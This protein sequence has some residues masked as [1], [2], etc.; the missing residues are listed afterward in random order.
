MTPKKIVS[1]IDI[2]TNSFHMVTAE[3]DTER[4]IQIISRDKEYVRL[5]ASGGDMKQINPDAIQRGIETLDKFSKI[6]NSYNSEIIAIATS[7]VREAENKSEFVD[8][9]FE[10]TGIEIQVITGREEGRLIYNGAIHALPVSGKKILLLDIGGGST[11][12]VFGKDDKIYFCKSVKL[13]TVRLWKKYF[14]KEQINDS[15]IDECLKFINGEWSKVLKDLRNLQFDSV[16]FTSGT[17]ENLIYVSSN[18]PKNGNS[19]LANGSTVTAKKLLATIDRIKN[20]KTVNKIAKIDGLDPKRADIILG[21]SLIAEYFINKLKIKELVFSSYALR[22]GILY[23]HIAEI[24]ERHDKDRFSNL[25]INTLINLV[26]KYGVDESHSLHIW[27]LS[28]KIFEALKAELG[29]TN[30]DKEMLEAA[31]Y[32]H[33]VGFFISHDSHHKHSYYLIKNSEMPGF[34]NDESELIANIARYHRKSLPKDRHENF[35][36]LRKPY[37][38]LIWILGGILRIAEGLDRRQNSYVK[39][40]NLEIKDN[41]VLIRIEKHQESSPDIEIW[42]AER[43]KQMLEIILNKKISILM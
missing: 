3:I 16:V 40:I 41:E 12:T 11:E 15:D 4:N 21:G 31:C 1:A 6:A 14:D 27:K 23:N 17:L 7:A 25:R 38:K 37:K 5:G 19:E 18:L 24:S 34:T 43:R 29:L 28:K 39:D 26:K 8:K 10:K 13:G 9:V 30:H 36:K 33:D 2:G 32:L 22:E 20:A 35:N 42:G